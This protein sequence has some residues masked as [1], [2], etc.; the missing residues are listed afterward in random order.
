MEAYA[1]CLACMQWGTA[2]LFSIGFSAKGVV[3]MGVTYKSY[4]I[5]SV[6]LGTLSEV[7]NVLQTLDL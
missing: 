6:L 5:F 7:W 1:T 3:A 2:L 4:I